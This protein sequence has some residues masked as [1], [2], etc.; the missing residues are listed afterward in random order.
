MDS[1]HKL[2]MLTRLVMYT[3]TWHALKTIGQLRTLS[4]NTYETAANT[5]LADRG[6]YSTEANSTER[7]MPVTSSDRMEGILVTERLAMRA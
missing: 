5:W 4:N 1:S 7:S 3:H 2:T 6:N